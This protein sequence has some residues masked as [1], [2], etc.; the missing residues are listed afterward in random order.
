MINPL[1]YVFG[2]SEIIFLGYNV[3]KDGIKPLAECVEAIRKFPKSTIIRALRKFLGM[4]NFYRRF[5]PHAPRIMTPLI[6]LFKGSNK[7]NAPVNGTERAERA[8]V[9]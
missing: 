6:E 3:N 1:K 5:I 4:V 9:V 2:V 7:G 8:F